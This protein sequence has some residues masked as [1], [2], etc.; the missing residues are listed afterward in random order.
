MKNPTTRRRPH[1]E[2][3]ENARFRLSA[4]CAVQTLGAGNQT[5]SVSTITFNLGSY[6]R[7]VSLAVSLWDGFRFSSLRSQGLPSPE[8]VRDAQTAAAEITTD[9]AQTRFRL[10]TQY[11]G[12]LVLGYADCPAAAPAE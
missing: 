7:E 6:T 8:F 3:H 9:P 10:D 4:S 1:P 11:G 5:A 12:N 2:I